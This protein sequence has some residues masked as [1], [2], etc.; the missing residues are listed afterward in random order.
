ME[1]KKRS[2]TKITNEIKAEIIASLIGGLGTREIARNL[3]ISPAAVHKIKVELEEKDP[4]LLPENCQPLIEDLLINSLKI[5]L[6]ALE[7]IARVAQDETYIRSNSA[8]QVADLHKQLTD[9]S[10][11]LLS[12]ANPNQ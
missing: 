8:G 4:K 5:H 2:Y 10:I 9:W 11:Q 7:T 12:A 1:D 6:G 3:S